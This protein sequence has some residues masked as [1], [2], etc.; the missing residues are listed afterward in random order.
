MRKVTVKIGLK[1]IN[2]QKGII[3]KVLLD[4]RAMG[5]VISS[6]FARKQMFKLKKIKR[7]IYVRN[8]N[9]FLNKERFIEYTVK[10]NSYY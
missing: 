9:S 8:V 6:K 1:R 3:V 2:I 10:I 7:L 4:S 5:L